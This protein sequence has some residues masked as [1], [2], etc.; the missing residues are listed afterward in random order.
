MLTFCVTPETHKQDNINIKYPSGLLGGMLVV[1]VSFFFSY[2]KS[3][4]GSI[5]YSYIIT[6]ISLRDGVKIG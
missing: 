6:I 1:V 4:G 5:I 3:S 2:H